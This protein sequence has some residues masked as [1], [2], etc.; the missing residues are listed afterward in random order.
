MDGSIN[1]EAELEE[2]DFAARRGRDAALHIM[3][4]LGRAPNL[5]T[6]KQFI[7]KTGR[8][9]VDTWTDEHEDHR[10]AGANYLPSTPY[11]A[12]LR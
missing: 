5:P 6:A 4:A 11:A 9:V 12:W 2:L 10:V 8:A 1:V 7:T 3:Y